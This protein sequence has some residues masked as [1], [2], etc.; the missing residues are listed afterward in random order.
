MLKDGFPISTRDKSSH[1]PVRST[2]PAAHQTRPR[3]FQLSPCKLEP[4]PSPLFTA[5]PKWSQPIIPPNSVTDACRYLH[6]APPIPAPGKFYLRAHLLT[7]FHPPADSTSLQNYHS[8]LLTWR[9]LTVKSLPQLQ[10]T[11]ASVLYQKE[12]RCFP[13]AQNF[14]IRK[15]PR[16][17]VWPLPT[18]SGFIS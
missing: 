3:P 6:H 13:H 12:I 1:T 14:A 7:P 16:C 2:L 10:H 18:F 5:H 17:L 8:D 4:L 11:Y 9:L 15:G